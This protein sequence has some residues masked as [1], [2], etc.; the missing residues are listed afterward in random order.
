MH[1]LK[2]LCGSMIDRASR[3]SMAEAA[4]HYLAGFSTNFVFDD[5]LFVLKSGDPAIKAIRKQLWLIYDDFQEHTHD[6]KWRLS[7]EQREIVVRTIMFLKSDI[8]YSWPQAPDWYESLRSLIWLF[9]L[10][11]GAK[12]LDRRFE[13]QDDDNTWPF[14]SHQEIEDAKN[15]PQY[16]APAP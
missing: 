7:E 14:R 8:E 9:T 1:L 16:L 2:A 12:A 15:A 13:Y 3:D 10:S 5:A 4:R 6:A 11:F